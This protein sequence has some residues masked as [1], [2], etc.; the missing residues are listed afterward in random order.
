MAFFT[1]DQNSSGG[2]FITNDSVAHYVIIEAV[3]AAHANEIAE[4]IGIYFNGC[5]DGIDCH[6]CGDRWYPVQDGA[7]GTAEPMIY[8]KT[9]EEYRSSG[10]GMFFINAGEPYAHVYYLNGEKR[11]YKR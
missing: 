7:D 6:C 11:T 8:D 9:V 3:N 2:S 1:Y 5:D 10:A 4:T